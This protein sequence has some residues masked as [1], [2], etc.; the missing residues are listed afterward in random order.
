MRNLTTS[1]LLAAAELEQLAT[2]LRHALLQ[3]TT[4]TELMRQVGT[5]LDYVNTART[6]LDQAI[7]QLGHAL[8][9][10]LSAEVCLPA[11]DVTIPATPVIPSTPSTPPTLTDDAVPLDAPAR[12][13]SR[14]KGQRSKC[15]GAVQSLTC[16]QCDWTVKLCEHHCKRPLMMVRAHIMV[17][18]EGRVLAANMRAGL[19]KWRAQKA[20][21]VATE[22]E[23]ES[24]IVTEAVTTPSV[25]PE[26]V[27]ATFVC[28]VQDADD[29]LCGAHVALSNLTLHLFSEHGKKCQLRQARLWF[30][31]VVDS[32][33]D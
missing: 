30:N 27:A 24:E 23:N 33:P 14:Y 25:V 3:P 15:Y 6:Q 29:R 11:T 22:T 8:R 19:A 10:G 28:K 1:A 20:N 31:E 2:G 13:C 7:Q 32:K 4:T 9:S 16:P 12:S 17:V 18:H 21:G 26:P 5:A